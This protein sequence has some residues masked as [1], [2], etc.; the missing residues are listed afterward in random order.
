MADLKCKFLGIE[1]PNPFWLASAPPTDKAYN[2]NR[3][4]EAG[5]GGAVW[6]TLGED[7]P[8]VNV[9][10]P[11]Y[12]AIHSND[13]RVIGFNN[14]ELITDRPLQTNLD[15]IRQIKRDW[16]DRALVVSVMFAMNKETWAKYMPMIE[17][18][19]CDGIELNFGCPHG[20]SER[21][22]GAAVGQVPEYIQMATEW[23]KD[24]ASVPVI[25]KLT[26]NI[27]H[28]VPP[29]KAAMDGGA[30]GVSLINTLNSIMRVDYD[31]LTMYPTTDGMG[32]HG[33]Y[34]GEAVKP[35]ALNMVAEIARTQATSQLPISGIGGVT[36]WRDAVDFLALGASN[37]QV[38]TAAMV[39]GFRI[40]D[41]LTDGL[42]TFLDEKGIASVADL[43]GRAVPSVTDW[44]HL[45]L[46]HV[47][48]AVIDQS[49]CIQCG[50]CHEVCEDTSHQAITHT[51]D[52]ERRFMV[53]DEECVGCN[54]CVSVCP[55]EDCITMKP[56]TG[57]VDPRTGQP[58]SDDRLEWTRHPNNPMR[59]DG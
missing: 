49:S 34:C 48:K 20:M 37:V 53:I 19:G 32:T 2:V 45:N 25:V 55:V 8:I 51:V 54:L 14:I 10:G 26:P 3:A 5:W 30:D 7:P 21:G 40:I 16:P 29:A 18:T 27:T 15:E 17:D 57:G 35:I 39:Y 33:G 42:S 59:R 38:C 11:R 12:A 36:D 31:T 56:L 22:M 58:I 43:V 47:E 4:F 6:K 52:G 44:Q 23:A 28:I 41:D 50:R 1:S 13:R 46:N 9:S 24:A